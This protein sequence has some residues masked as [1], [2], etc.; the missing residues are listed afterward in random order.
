MTLRDPRH[1][2][3]ETLRLAALL[4]LGLLSASLTVAILHSGGL[5]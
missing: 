4:C 2:W 3:S 5:P 1:D